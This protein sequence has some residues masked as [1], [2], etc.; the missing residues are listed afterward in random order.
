[1]LKYLVKRLLQAVPL[2][3]LITMLCF[4]LINLAPYDAMDAKVTD[5][6]TPADI[7]QMREEMGLNDPIP[8]QY[9]RWVKGLLQ[10]D[11]GQSLINRTNIAT[12]LKEKIPNTIK[13]VLPAYATAFLLA[14]ALGLIAGRYKNTW[15]DKLINST[16]SIGLSVPTFWVALLFI[17]FFGLKLDLFPVMGMHSL[18]EDSFEDFLHHFVLPYAVLTIGFLPDLVR[19]VRSSTVTQFDEEYVTVQRA[20]GSSSGTILLRHVSKNVLLP[21]ITKLGMALPMLV[22]G[23]VITETVF[24]WPGIGVYFTTAIRNLDY[25][26]VMV[27]LVLSGS[28]VILGNLISD[29][30]CAVIDPRIRIGR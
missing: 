10:G 1:M 2:L 5:K 15:V 30:L 28:L 9:L 4:T 21:M 13:L 17:Y 26:V 19:Y 23:A 24:A 16:A 22:T 18:G 7:E 3:I 14:I 8:V 29:I 27:V 6:M 25:P 11:L 12:D 20:F